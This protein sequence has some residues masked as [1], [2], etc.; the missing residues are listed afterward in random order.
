MTKS[1]EISQKRIQTLETQKK[2][3]QNDKEKLIVNIGVLEK[4]VEAWRKM[5]DSEKRNAEDLKR[6]KELL[7]K[8]F[9][10]INGI[11]IQ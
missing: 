3:L 6:E 8:S 5:C 4:E 11:D 9:Q 2:D 1:K 10:R 7:H